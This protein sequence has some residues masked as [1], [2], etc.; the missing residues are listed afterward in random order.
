MLGFGD[1]KHYKYA[2]DQFFY[3]N[4]SILAQMFRFYDN[5]LRIMK[6]CNKKKIGNDGA[7]IEC[8]F[9]LYITKFNNINIKRSNI[10]GFFIR[11]LN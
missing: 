4:Q 5:I 11:E 7:L 6:Y 10:S 8:I 2:N 9:Y 1:F 3:H